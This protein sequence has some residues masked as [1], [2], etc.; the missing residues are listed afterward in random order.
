MRSRRITLGRNPISFLC[1]PLPSLLITIPRPPATLGL[2]SRPEFSEAGDTE[3]GTLGNKL[4]TP[5]R[6][7]IHGLASYFR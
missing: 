6:R 2:V 1:F 4:S 7:F 3:G 5:E